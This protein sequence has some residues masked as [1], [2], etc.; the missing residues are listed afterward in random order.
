MTHSDLQH[1]HGNHLALGLLR[2]DNMPLIASF[3]Y[4][5]FKEQ[6]RLKIDEVELS[7]MLYDHLAGINLD[8]AEPIYPLGPNR[9]LNEWTES[10]FLTRSYEKQKDHAIYQLTSGSELAL[11]WLASLQ[12]SEFV[13]TE[14]KLL[15]ILHL[16]QNLIENTTAREE[17]R[18]AQLEEQKARI[19]QQ[20]DS[21]LAGEPLEQLN[22][23]RIRERFFEMERLANELLSDFREIEENF[24]ALDKRAR[25]KQL[26]KG[27]SR[28]QVVGE[29]LDAHDQLWDS[30][31]GRSFSAFWELLMNGE[32]QENLE[33]MINDLRELPQLTQEGRRSTISRLKVNLMEV[34]GQVNQ[35]NHQLIAQLRRFL[36]AQVLLEHKKM[37]DTI[38]AFQRLAIAN[39][40]DIPLKKPFFELADK[41]G[42]DFFLNRPFFSPT[43]RPV[44][45]H[46]PVEEGRSDVKATSLFE[47]VYVDQEQLKQNIRYL[48]RRRP[49]VTLSEVCEVYPVKKGLSELV[50]YIEVARRDTKAIIDEQEEVIIEVN[51]PGHN[52]QQGQNYSVP[53]V[54]FTS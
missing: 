52:G 11:R 15:Q 48:L 41:P 26:D 18:L 25:E 22:D 51:D 10:G 37:N 33:K 7:D 44:I 34:G 4:L 49:Q 1:L 14:S 29:V 45:T 21:I 19:Q 27:M 38:E 20:M 6:N 47:Q 13:G 50:A 5:A 40:E 31:Q 8:R 16:L 42:I 39:K 32:Q 35:S 2:K 17:E 28:G 9:Y 12:K 43:E 23:T 36:D 46:E 30:D 3:L 54:I 24:Q 53:N